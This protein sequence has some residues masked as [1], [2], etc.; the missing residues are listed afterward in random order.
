MITTHKSTVPFFAL[1]GHLLLTILIADSDQHCTP[2]HWQS[3][4]IKRV[5]RS[6]LA[7]ECLAL[8]NAVDHAFYLKNVMSDMLGFDLEIHCHTDNQSLVDSLHSSTNVKEDKR[9][10]LDVCSLKEMME[11]KELHSVKWVSKN[12]QIADAMTKSGASPLALQ[13]VVCSGELLSNSGW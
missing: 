11:R 6:T 2:I 10:V 8:Q 5:V 9:L 4:K 13:R 12:G 1:D 7:A 3:K